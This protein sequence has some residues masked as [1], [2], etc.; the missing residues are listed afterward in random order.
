M[1]ASG[2]VGANLLKLLLQVRSDVYG[3]AFAT[4]A[5]RLQD[6]PDVNVFTLDLL[7]PQSARAVMREVQPGTVFDCVAYGAYSFENDPE[8]IYNTNVSSKA[9]LVEL[10]CEMGTHCYIHAGSSS[11]YGERADQP[12][13]ESALHPNSHYAVAKAAAAHLVYFAGQHR[14]LRCANLRLY[15]VYGPLEEPSRLMPTLIANAL[16]GTYPSLVAPHVSRD[17]L[18]VDDACEAFVDAAL[19]LPPNLHGHSF[20]IGTGVSTTI[21]ELALLARD[22]FRIDDVPA[23]STMPNRNWDFQGRWR[24]RTDKA[25][26]QL[27]WKSRTSLRDGLLLFADWYR[28]CAN[29]TLYRRQAKGSSTPR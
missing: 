13:E 15:S 19:R 3:T 25:E 1:G 5:W 20:N 8:R 22:L 9:R 16:S 28:V 10:L 27:A 26:S 11:E 4:P 7:V 24:A 14:S 6:V 29:P 17:Y 12:S 21:E 23:F 2:F 18:Y